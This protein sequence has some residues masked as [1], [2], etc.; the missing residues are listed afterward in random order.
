MLPITLAMEPLQLV[1][2]IDYAPDSELFI[3]KI[4]EGTPSRRLEVVGTNEWKVRT[5]SPMSFG[6]PSNQT[7][8]YGA[9]E[10]A[11]TIAGH[12]KGVL[13]FLQLHQ[14][15]GRRLLARIRALRPAQKEE[16]LGMGICIASSS[17]P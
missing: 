10:D 1:L 3:A 9:I 8:G 6:Y 14:T 7:E 11:D 17:W 2:L 12:S 5:L 15:S 16:P 13:A 4:A